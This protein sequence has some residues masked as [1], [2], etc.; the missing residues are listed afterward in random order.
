LSLTEASQSPAARGGTVNPPPAASHLLSGLPS[1][2]PPGEQRGSLALGAPQRPLRFRSRARGPSVQGVAAPA[3]TRARPPVDRACPPGRPAGTCRRCGG[4]ASGDGGV[5][6]ATRGAGRADASAFRLF[7]RA[8]GEGPLVGCRLVGLTSPRVFWNFSFF[9][10]SEP[11]RPD[12]RCKLCWSDDPRLIQDL[13]VVN[14]GPACL[15][16]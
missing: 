3:L 16:C 5:W 8:R 13:K 2:R 1:R 14:F 4:R 9:I 7:V 6:R 15:T 12:L 10:Y 11:S